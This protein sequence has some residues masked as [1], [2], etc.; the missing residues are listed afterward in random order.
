MASSDTPADFGWSRLAL[1]GV[2]VVDVPGDH[3]SMMQKPNVGV[4]AARIDDALQ[5][6]TDR[7]NS[8]GSTL[9]LTHV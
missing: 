4:L 6:A 9:E 1:G 2:E 3:M 8:V 5:Q 7:V